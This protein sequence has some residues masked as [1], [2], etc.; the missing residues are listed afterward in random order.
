M[1]SPEYSR[2]G[3]A[4][5]RLRNLMRSQAFLPAKKRALEK[6]PSCF[7]FIGGKTKHININFWG[8]SRSKTNNGRETGPQG[9]DLRVDP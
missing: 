5:P 2:G 9:S 3:A 6:M 1:P 8:V 7:V 4:R